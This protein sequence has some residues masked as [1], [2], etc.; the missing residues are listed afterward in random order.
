MKRPRRFNIGLLIKTLGRCSH[1]IKL[2]GLSS[3]LVSY[4]AN[5]GADKNT[6]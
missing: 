2:E 5:E 6:R 1:A 3:S 4:T